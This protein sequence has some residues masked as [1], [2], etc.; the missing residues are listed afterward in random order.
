LIAPKLSNTGGAK[1]SGKGMLPVCRKPAAVVAG[2][3]VARRP[4][5]PSTIA[6]GDGPPMNP[7]KWL[8]VCIK[9]S[10]LRC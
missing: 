7:A 9:C 3:G 1:A 8:E 5:A 4:P 6:A 10:P 2:L